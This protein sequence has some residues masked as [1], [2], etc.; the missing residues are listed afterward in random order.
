MRTSTLIPFGLLAAADQHSRPQHTYAEETSSQMSELTMSVDAYY[1]STAEEMEETEE[2]MQLLADQLFLRHRHWPSRGAQGGGGGGSGRRD[3]DDEQMSQ[4]SDG[5]RAMRA[6]LDVSG[7]LDAFSMMDN[8]ASQ[9]VQQRIRAFY[10]RNSAYERALKLARVIDHDD[11]A[12]VHGVDNSN[13]PIYITFVLGTYSLLCYVAY[14]VFICT[15]GN[16]EANFAGSSLRDAAHS[17]TFSSSLTFALGCT[18]PMLTEL[19][20]SARSWLSLRCC[21]LLGRDRSND[22]HGQSQSQ[23]QS[24]RSRQHRYSDNFLKRTGLARI[25]FSLSVAAP[26]IIMIAMLDR[27]FEADSFSITTIFWQYSMFGAIATAFSS[28]YQPNIISLRGVPRFGQMVGCAMS[29]LFSTG[30]LIQAIGT[31]WQEH[32][33]I[34]SRVAIPFQSLSAMLFTWF[35]FNLVTKVLRGEMRS[36]L[37]G[38]L[39]SPMTMGVISMVAG[40]SLMLAFDYGLLLATMSP[41]GIDTTPFAAAMHVYNK[42]IIVILLGILPITAANQSMRRTKGALERVLSLSTAEQTQDGVPLHVSVGP[43]DDASVGLGEG[44]GEGEGED[45]GE[46]GGEDGGEEGGLGVGVEAEDGG[47]DTDVEGGGG[48]R[49]RGGGQNAVLSR[50]YLMAMRASV[51]GPNEARA[52]AAAV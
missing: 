8:R 14:L 42:S 34:C 25:S 21:R 51:D 3:T 38:T 16:E 30:N 48:S 36:P 20:I 11:D 12:A 43:S 18:A 1:R 31:L 35:C 44:E 2:V 50:A 10:A 19:L 40:F 23:S 7:E 24:R 39:I 52:A 28:K 45:G 32:F 13:Y 6:S 33:V 9:Q 49:G 47:A 4:L 46:G 41:N 37:D 27:G 29:L 15:P 5:S 17:G 22:R 26:C